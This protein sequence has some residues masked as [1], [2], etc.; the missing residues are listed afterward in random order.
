MVP[1]VCLAKFLPW[2]TERHR[3][4]LTVRPELTGDIQVRETT[5]ISHAKLGGTYPLDG[6]ACPSSG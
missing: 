4:F 1:S 2:C 3:I 5:I 6:P